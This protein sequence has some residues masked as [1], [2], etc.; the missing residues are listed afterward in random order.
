M[1]NGCS[2]QV[3]APNN[4]LTISRGP[5]YVR[6]LRLF[7]PFDREGGRLATRRG[8]R[9]GTKAFDGTTQAGFSG[10]GRNMRASSTRSSQ[11]PTLYCGKPFAGEWKGSIEATAKIPVRCGLTQLDYLSPQT[12]GLFDRIPPPPDSRTLMDRLTVA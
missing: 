3:D 12:S 2:R 4:T 9:G 6:G 1:T 5:V 8:T 11:E 7:C 10:D